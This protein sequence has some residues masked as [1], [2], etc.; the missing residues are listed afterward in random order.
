MTSQQRFRETMAFGLPDRVP[1][2]EEG[3]R[4]DV[5]KAWY[6]Q[7]LD[8]KARLSELFLTDHFEEID[9]ELDPRPEPRSWPEH[10]RDLDRFKEKLNPEDSSRWPGGWKKHLITWKNTD[11]LVFLRIH[12]GFFLS[13]GTDTWQRFDRIMSLVAENPAFIEQYMNI[14]A[15]FACRLLERILN[16][17]EIDAA[18]FSEPIGGNEGPLLS[19][20]MYESLV[21]TSYQPLIRLLQLKGIKTIIFRTYANAKIYIPSILKFGMNCLWAC[22]TNADVMDYRLLRK[23]YGPDL[24]LIGGIDL[25]VLRG[26][27]EAIRREIMDK[28][29]P[30]IAEGGYVPLADGRV[31]ADIRFENYCYYRQ[32]LEEVTTS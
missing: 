13:L 30:L 6:E 22:E 32:L 28:V 23:E 15:E 26:D 7:G 25:D 29:P 31:R 9:P 17:I 11:Q 27:K 21:L 14:Q 1:Y 3:I 8:R 24:R 19:P 2:F 10:I 12:R 5:L 16:D 4:Q 18:V 20:Q